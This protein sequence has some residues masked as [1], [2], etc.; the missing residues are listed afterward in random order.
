MS[1]GSGKLT[2]MA[3]S[4]HK[5]TGVVPD[6]EERKAS[7][8]IDL[9][10]MS[11]NSF[12]SN[13]VLA[14]SK[15]VT[16]IHSEQYDMKKHKI[17]TEPNNTTI[18]DPKCSVIFE[19]DEVIYERN[20]KTTKMSKRGGSGEKTSPSQNKSLGKQGESPIVSI[21]YLPQVVASSI[22]ME[23][24]S[25][26]LAPIKTSSVST[27]VMYP[28][29]ETSLLGKHGKAEKFLNDIERTLHEQ[30]NVN[31][32]MHKKLKEMKKNLNMHHFILNRKASAERKKIYLNSKL[33]VVHEKP[34]KSQ[35]K[36]ELEFELKEM[37]R[38]FQSVSPVKS[39]EKAL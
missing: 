22:T 35:R 27:S 39:E 31:E 28:I 25:L 16:V 21:N 7:E 2:P 26:S 18:G 13:N 34:E 30:K 14:R 3:K 11:V 24:P 17:Q 6:F 4:A 1:S 29:N 37:E 15:D 5:Q 12:G 38:E 33:R 20:N 9:L 23:K 8:F 32:L 36:K 10:E 19:E